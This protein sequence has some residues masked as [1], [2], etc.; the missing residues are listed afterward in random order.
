M[1]LQTSLSTLVETIVALSGAVDL[2]SSKSFRTLGD[3]KKGYRGFLASLGQ[4]DIDVAGD[5]P[6]WVTKPDEASKLRSYFSND[7]LL[8]DKAQAVVIGESQDH[9]CAKKQERL[10]AALQELALY[11]PAHAEIFAAVI[12]D[13]FV[14]PSSVAKGGSTSQAI[15]V[16]WANPKVTYTTSDIVE[17]LVHELT[18][19]TMFLDELRYTHY[20]YSQVLDRST[21]AHSA[22]LNVARPLDKV[23]HSIVVAVEVLLFRAKF[24]GHP[25][26]PRVHPPTEIMIGQLRDSISSTEKAIQTSTA[27]FRARATELL[28]NAKQVLTSEFGGSGGRPCASRACGGA[29]G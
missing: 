26:S 20:S 3:L 1:I 13:I 9:E 23:L 8:D 27:V 11:S 22:I 29:V 4:R 25:V 7:S 5:Q 14:L 21:W 2:E 28:E 16:I 18:H 6:A 24:L 12:T 15:G 10:A 17:I 19:H